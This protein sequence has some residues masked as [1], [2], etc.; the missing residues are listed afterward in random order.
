[1]ENEFTSEE[2]KILEPYFTN[3]DSPIFALRN[4]PEVV[5]GALFSRYSRTTKSLRRVL[6]DEFI[7]N[8][9][10]GFSEIA[11]NVEV[12]SAEKQ[13]IAT[14]KAEE[15]YDRVLVGYGDDSVAEL[16]GGHIACE[17]VSMIASKV[18][19]DARIGISP[20]EKST[21]Y[22]YFNQKNS[23]GNYNYYRGKELVDCDFGEQ[24][25]QTCD[26]LFDTY[27][28]LL[29]RMQK[30]VM[31]RHPKEADVTDRAYQAT[32]RA[33]AFDIVR[34]IL[35]ASA[36][37]NLGLFGNGRAFEYLLLKMYA[38]D[39]PEI[40]GIANGMQN[41]L[42]KIIPSFV[43]RANDQYG[44]GTQQYL[45]DT[46]IAVEK[47]AGELPREKGKDASEVELIDFDSDAQEKVVAAI[48]YQ[49]TN[50]P[51]KQLLE[52]VRGMGVEKQI[53]IFNEYVSGRKNRRHKTGRALE[54]TYY[55]FDILGNFG[56]FRDLH[57]HRM[58]SQERQLLGCS[59]GYDIPREIIEAG[60][61]TQYRKVMD[62]A[63]KT[64]ELIGK[65]SP[66]L[67]QYAVPLAYKL[68]WYFK[69][70]LREAFHMAEL[71]SMQQGHPDY[72]RVA[73]KIHAEIAKVHPVF[74]A[75]MKFVDM[76]EYAL[77]R[78]D[79]EKRIDKKLEEM[80]KKYSTN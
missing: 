15:F 60:F 67:A 37:T 2:R 49:N 78:L 42:N 10:M 19:E 24:Y 43:K 61:E 26:M 41:E 6:L 80:N 68:R 31:T 52:I 79:A 58:L 63:F 7:L 40:N 18:L 20:L 36:L 44:K 57:R 73:Q 11:G 56:Q 1:M 72:R 32:I 47:I 16:G 71:R 62:E 65:S 28:D 35:P 59:N 9:E 74:A 50:M 51:L 39:L 14:Q 12:G 53:A 54:N 76:K 48:L 13:I 33:K 30:F 3:L 34:G 55:T 38:S 8:K 70:N 5:M 66:K 69:M 45:K 23:E 22:V 46:R 17:Q 75:Q 4:M 21:R 29:E 25:V 77:E 27:S 64:W